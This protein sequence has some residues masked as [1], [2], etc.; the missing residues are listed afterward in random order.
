MRADELGFEIWCE[1]FVR[2]GHI[3]HLTI[4][5]EDEGRYLERIKR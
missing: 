2:V 1:P 3:G 5:P 4:Y